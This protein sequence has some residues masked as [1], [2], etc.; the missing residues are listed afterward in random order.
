MQSRA[1]PFSRGSEN[2]RTFFVRT[3]YFLFCLLGSKL[4]FHT[5][6]FRSVASWHYRGVL[7][8]SF[9]W[10]LWVWP[11]RVLHRLQ[12]AARGAVRHSRNI[13]TS[14]LDIVCCDGLVLCS[15]TRCD[16]TRGCPSD[17]RKFRPGRGTTTYIGPKS[18]AGKWPTMRSQKMSVSRRYRAVAGRYP[19]GW[20]VSHIGGR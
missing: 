14:H 15:G 8:T 13:A 4:C 19:G 7:L 16:R 18:E 17:P 6:F 20:F 3:N 9:L 2:A 5:H 1:R 10:T 11:G 12:L